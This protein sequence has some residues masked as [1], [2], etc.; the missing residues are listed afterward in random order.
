MLEPI[1]DQWKLMEKE[2]HHLT[3]VWTCK[4]KLV[5]SGVSGKTI[6]SII[7]IYTQNLQVSIST[8]AFHYLPSLS[9][10]VKDPEVVCTSEEQSHNFFFL[11]GLG[12]YSNFSIIYLYGQFERFLGNDLSAEKKYGKVRELK[13]FLNY[14]YI[15]NYINK[16]TI[17]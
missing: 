7:E 12:V 15:I 17:P 11:H 6:A 4:K 2:G 1:M 14:R 10:E 16:E 9:L 8:F 5:E 13:C 3:S